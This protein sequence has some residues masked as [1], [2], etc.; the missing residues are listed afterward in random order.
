MEA[1][2]GSTTNYLGILVKQQNATQQ[3]YPVDDIPKY[4]VYLKKRGY[5]ADGNVRSS[6]G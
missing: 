1:L 6:F 3:K 5:V 2:N 4:V